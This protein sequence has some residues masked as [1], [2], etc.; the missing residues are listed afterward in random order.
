VTRSDVFRA[1]DMINGYRLLEDF[2]VVGAGLSEWSFAERGGRIFFIKRFLSPTYPDADA[3]GS[4]RIKAKK[5][6]R[7][8]AFEAHHRGIQ[9][10][11]APL[12]TY[13]GNLIATLDFFRVGAKYYKV[14]EKVDVAGLQTR[15][16][17]ALDFPA[18][19][20]LLK[21]VAHSLK[22]LHDLHIVH[23][24]LKPSNVMIKRTELGYTTKLIDFD[25]SYIVGSP[26]PPEEIVG[27]MNY[28]SPELVRYIQGS[29]APGELTEASD[30]FALGLIY[31]EY[32]TGAMPPFDPAHHEAAIAVLHGQALKV[33][34][35]RAPTSVNQLV[36]RML[37]PDPAARPS[38]AQV[39]STLMGLRG[40]GASSTTA[41]APVPIRTTV[42]T[43]AE[44]QRPVRRD[45]PPRR[46]PHL[47]HRLPPRYLIR[48][49]PSTPP[50]GPGLAG[51][52]F[53]VGCSASSKSGDHGEPAVA[54]QRVRDGEPGWPRVLGLR[55]RDDPP[56]SRSHRR[57]R[58]RRTGPATP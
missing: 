49:H 52:Y 21:T 31:A 10:A 46:P 45:R 26:P 50:T 3:P 55:R 29:A 16:V 13:G 37:L 23:S 7:C 17:A 42:A 9:A 53:W 48:R 15:D 6:A 30:I 58:P 18:Q 24:D 2:R 35:S 57:P 51:G 20:V 43:R 41:R 44:P 4:E 39:H 1:G 28:Y 14:T 54:V 5:R 56:V 40:G 12:T 36:E 8:A 19:L 47:Q 25:S 38:V 32:L 34:S 22:I 27:T 11:M 33:G